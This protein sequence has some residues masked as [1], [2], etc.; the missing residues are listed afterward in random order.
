MIARAAAAWLLFAASNAHAERLDASEIFKP[1]PRLR[2][3]SMRMRLT[4][5]EQQGRGYQSQ[6]DRPSAA[7]PGSEAVS[8]TQ[9]QLEVVASHGDKLTY[10]L[11]V[12]VD[13]VTAASPDAID[14]LSTA[15]R[16]NEAASLDLTA[17]YRRTP[18]NEL[19]LRTAFH[20]EE[21]FRSWLVGVGGSHALADDNTVIAYSLNQVFD[22]LDRFDLRGARHGAGFRSSTNANLGLT[23]LLSP[24]TIG[25][26][27]YGVTVQLGELSNTWNAVPLA[28]GGL[29]DERLPRL[30]H[31]HAFVGRLT[32]ALPWRGS[33]RAG[34][35]FY[36]DDWGIKAHTLDAALYQRITRYVYLRANYRFHTQTAADFFTLAASPDEA[37]PRTADSDLQ[38]FH[39]HAAGGFL[40]VDL[41]LRRHARGLHFDLGYE[42]YVRTNNL[43]M[44]VY[45]CSFALLF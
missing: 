30:R 32:Q 9:P 20:I 22:W 38:A 41:E 37:G 1:R 44:D 24:S 15:S 25:Q 13:V 31:R 40:A 19:S 39:A 17:S 2:V 26:L 35:R 27:N 7:M 45:T 12:P 16:T 21:P 4:H 18:S 10:R 8:V 34:Y 36:V 3:E 11:W 23:Q 42:R 33:I 5:F 14:A 6:A 29:G 43:Q 28:S